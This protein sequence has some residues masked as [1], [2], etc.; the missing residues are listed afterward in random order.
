MGLDDLRGTVANR[1]GEES[2]WREEEDQ[3]GPSDVVVLV[4]DHRCRAEEVDLALKDGME[5]GQT[6]SDRARDRLEWHAAHEAASPSTAVECEAASWP[7]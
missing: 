3:R 6:A 2:D 7:S 5:V 1:N 4:G